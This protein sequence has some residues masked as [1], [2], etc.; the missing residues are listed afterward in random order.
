MQSEGFGEKLQFIS[1]NY[2]LGS[3]NLIQDGVYRS[4]TTSNSLTVVLMASCC[5]MG[6]GFVSGQRWHAVQAQH[7]GNLFL[8]VHFPAAAAAGV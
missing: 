5:E 1:E 3:E 8:T 2:V 4:T 7:R 6:S